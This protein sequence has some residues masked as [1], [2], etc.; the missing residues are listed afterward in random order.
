[1]KSTRI[2]L[3]CT[4]VFVLLASGLACTNGRCLGDICTYDGKQP[5]YTR[6][7]TDRDRIHLVEN[8]NAVD[9]TWQQLEAFLV[10]DNTDKEAYDLQTHACGIFAEELQNNA[11]AAG[12]RAAWVGIDF[13]EGGDG[14]ALNAFNTTD[15][16]LVFIDCTSGNSSDAAQNQQGKIWGVAD[17]WDKVAYLSIG[18]EYGLISLSAAT[19]PEYECYEAYKHQKADFEAA[20]QQYSDDV[21]AYNDWIESRMHH[22]SP[23]DYDKAQKDKSDLDARL[24]ALDKEGDALGAFWEPL[25]NVSSIDIYW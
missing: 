10:A 25:G 23:A 12:I 11:E 3:V 2:I 19:C 22:F 18:Q 13:S 20:W 4:I 16:G 24:R 17:S 9:P 1:M 21:Q 5:P 8:P 6:S 15:R 14:H 7:V